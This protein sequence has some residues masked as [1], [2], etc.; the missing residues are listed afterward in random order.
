M[1]KQDR[2]FMAALVF[3]QTGILVMAISM[4]SKFW[5]GQIQECKQLSQLAEL[6]DWL[7]GENHKKEAEAKIIQ[8]KQ[9]YET[10]GIGTEEP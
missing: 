6:R 7:K 9:H 2:K 10:Q 8:M 5:H 4:S 3:L 1:N